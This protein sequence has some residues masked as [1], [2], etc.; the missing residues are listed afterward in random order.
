M[1]TY[2]SLLPKTG[3]TTSY[4]TGDD[5]DLEKGVAH[6]FTVLDTG[7]HSGTT[8]ITM[9][10]FTESK[11][12]NCVQDNVTGLMWVKNP[13]AGIGSDP[14]LKGAVGIM[15]WTTDG[16]GVGIFPYVDLANAAS[17]AGYTDWRIPNFVEILTILDHENMNLFAIF[18]WIGQ[19]LWSSTTLKNNTTFA[20]SLSMNS[21]TAFD[22]T[23]LMY[24]IFVRGSPTAPV[25]GNSLIGGMVGE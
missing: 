19:N 23:W 20:Y 5:G 8:D 25:A 4:V 14:Y 6:S 10:G 1:T 15:P 12:N 11:S 18:D 2:T 9:N 22:K 7:Q 21:Q 3:Q 13:S 24:C 16:D 17:L